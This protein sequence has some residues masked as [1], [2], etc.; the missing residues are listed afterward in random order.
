MSKRYC[1]LLLN[2]AA[3]ILFLCAGSAFASLEEIKTA[4]LKEDYQ[5][6]KTL[7]EAALAAKSL[8]AQEEE[9][10][11]YLALSQLYLGQIEKARGN[12]QKVVD[13][14]KNMDL[15]D[16]ATIGVISSYYLNGDYRA[17]LKRSHQLLSERPNSNYLS[18]VYLK[19][20]RANL[21]LRNWE[22]ARRFLLKV[23]TD[24]PDSLEAYTAKKLLEEKQFFTVQV[25]A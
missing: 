12:F 8:G 5:T 2:I 21:K 3:C 1:L 11:Y 14:T 9:V 15:S 10:L 7:S 25:G 23:V 6:A 13:S 16:Q 17:S 22:P 4:I 19:I 20:A 24:F 18:L